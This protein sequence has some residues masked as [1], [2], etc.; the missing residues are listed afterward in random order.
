MNFREIAT[1]EIIRTLR[2]RII[3]GKGQKRS[4][5]SEL[6]TRYLSNETSEDEKSEIR[7]FDSEI[8]I[9]KFGRTCLPPGV[10]QRGPVTPPKMEGKP[11]RM[12]IFGP[13]GLTIRNI[14]KS[15]D[16]LQKTLL[17]EI[18]SHYLRHQKGILNR[19]LYRRFEKIRVVEALS[20]LR[21]A[22]YEI[23]DYH[24]P[25]HRFE[26]TI[27][28]FLVC[29]EAEKYESRLVGFLDYLEMLYK[30]RPEQTSVSKDEIAGVLKLNA[31]EAWQFYFL[32]SKANLCGNA[33]YNVSEQ[34]WEFQ[35]FR[36]VDDLP[37]CTSKEDFLYSKIIYGNRSSGRA[38][39]DEIK[40]V[41][42]IV[43][44]EPAYKLLTPFFNRVWTN[45][46]MRRTPE[47]E[48]SL[49]RRFGK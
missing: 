19:D 47:D 46:G 18:T 48:A 3:S 40:S 29:S 12:K 20:P 42:K 9:P 44:D 7:V 4:F 45:C 27:L 26:P 33:S 24:A 34:K 25:C 22:V 11:L 21:G 31:D 43:D 30:T 10:I 13:D 49:V 1:T 14:R 15:L 5:L 6:Q 17:D 39:Q 8:F 28:G 36:E 2:E 38:I 37:G 23:E 41:L 35:I 32:A 16:E